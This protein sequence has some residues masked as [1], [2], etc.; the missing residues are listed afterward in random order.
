MDDVFGVPKPRREDNIQTDHRDTECEFLDLIQL[1]RIS[2][3]F[4]FLLL[5]KQQL[6]ARCHKIDN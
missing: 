4:F 3:K 6:T 2:I 1:V 5:S